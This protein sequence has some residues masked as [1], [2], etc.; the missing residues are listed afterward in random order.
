MDNEICPN[1]GHRN[2]TGRSIDLWEFSSPNNCLMEE[3]IK[4][5]GGEG[6]GRGDGCRVNDGRGV[7]GADDGMNSLSA[8]CGGK[9]VA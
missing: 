4:R 8:P 5:G 9:F 3:V 7:G 6:E 1:S 2:E